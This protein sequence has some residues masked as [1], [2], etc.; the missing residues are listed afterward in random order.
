MSSSI[1]SSEELAQA[2]AAGFYFK[3]KQYT[4]PDFLVDDVDEFEKEGMEDLVGMLGE[5][6]DEE[7]KAEQIAAYV[8]KLQSYLDVLEVAVLQDL[9][10]ATSLLALVERRISE[11]QNLAQS[12][13]LEEEDDS[14]EES[15]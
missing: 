15:D 14:E 1:L 4:V 10:D 7:S 8:E 12:K 6:L 9:P 11:G 13:T 5:T 2:E 3:E